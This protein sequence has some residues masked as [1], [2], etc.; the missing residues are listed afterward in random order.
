MKRISIILSCAFLLAACAVGP[1][2][3][4]PDVDTPKAWHFEEKEAKA[5]INVKWWEAFNDPVLNDIVE[6]ALK[7]NKDLLIATARIEEYTGRYISTRGD[8]FPQASASGSVARQRASQE[9]I[10]GWQ[11]G[12]SPVYNNYQASLNASWEIDFWGKYRRATEAARANLL[13]QEESRRVVLLSL[14]TSAASTYINLRNLDRQLEIAQNTLKTRKDSLDLFELRFSGGVISELELSQVKSEYE[15]ARAA[16]PQIEKS[17]AQ[18][19]NALNILL[20]R[21]PGPVNRGK[22]I[23]QL[24]IPEVP[25]GLPSDVLERRPDIRQAEQNLIS[26]NANIGV[27]RAA[28][29]P[30]ISLTGMFGSASTDFSK[31]FS[32]PARTWSFG[33]SVTAPIFM[34]GRIYGQVKAAEAVQKELLLQYQQTIQTA[35]REVEDSL[36]DQRKSREKMEA[37]GEQV[38]SLRTYRDLANLRY[39]N[40]YSSYLEVLDAERNLY[41]LE[42]NYI[43]TK[44]DIFNAMFNLYKAMGGG[45]VMEKAK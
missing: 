43:Q 2:Y 34:A 1:D 19:E 20:G 8:L 6:T 12:L 13:S 44:G 10:S 38:K 28:Y 23:D 16:I 32:G 11:T 27:A 3:K 36:V 21:N 17:I 25:A 40:G 14:I 18:T 42:I 45:W 4:R 15:S 29:F 33:G 24:A 41:S 5:I 7:D 26:A 37:Q 9:T 35:F 31:L 39:E 22:T 30:S